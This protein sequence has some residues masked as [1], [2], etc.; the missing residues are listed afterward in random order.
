MAK[1]PAKPRTSPLKS[2]T[3]RKTTKAETPPPTPAAT[4]HTSKYT[5]GDHVSHPIFGEGTVTGIDGEKLTIQFADNVVKQ[6]IEG[7][8]SRRKQ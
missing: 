7:Y 8:V 3:P 1:K 4:V 2:S 6:I 5:I